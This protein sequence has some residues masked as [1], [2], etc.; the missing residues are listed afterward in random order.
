VIAFLFFRAYRE[1]IRKGNDQRTSRSKPIT[2]STSQPQFTMNDV[3]QLK[4]MDILLSMSPSTK[5]QHLLDA[6]AEEQP[7]EEPFPWLR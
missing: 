7:A 5:P 2:E 1:M 4:M 6:P 3:I